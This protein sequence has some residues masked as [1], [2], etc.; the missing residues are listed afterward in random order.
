M[1][2]CSEFYLISN[3]TCFL[4]VWH[5]EKEEGS[6]SARGHFSRWHWRIRKHQ[7]KTR[8]WTA[9]EATPRAEQGGASG[10]AGSLVSRKGQDPPLGPPTGWPPFILSFITDVVTLCWPSRGG[11]TRVPCHQA[12][13]HRLSVWSLNLERVLHFYTAGKK[14]KKNI[15]WP[16]K[17]MW[18]SNSSIHK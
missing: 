16:M 7:G 5:L 18:H 17:I 10:G 3:L 12:T 14:S 2:I 4:V 6:V 9:L 8:K 13:A 1:E 15:S 11:G